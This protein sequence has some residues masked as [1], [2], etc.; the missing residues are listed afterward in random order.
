M[1]QNHDKTVEHNTRQGRSAR[2]G[3]RRG[4]HALSEST[5]T[6]G[7]APPSLRLLQAVAPLDTSLLPRATRSSLLCRLCNWR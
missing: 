5:A 4:R 2:T 6:D 7:P 3:R 1:Q